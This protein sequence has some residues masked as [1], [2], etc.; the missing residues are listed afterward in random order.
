MEGEGESWENCLGRRRGEGK[1]KGREEGKRK[2]HFELERIEI[3][4]EVG[5]VGRGGGNE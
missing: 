1:G 3:G 4:D 5:K 2:I